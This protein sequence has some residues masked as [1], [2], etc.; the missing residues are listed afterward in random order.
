MNSFLVFA[1]AAWLALSLFISGDA[2]REARL[3]ASIFAA[4]GILASRHKEGK[5]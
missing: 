3:H 1:A 2:Q 4:A 5:P